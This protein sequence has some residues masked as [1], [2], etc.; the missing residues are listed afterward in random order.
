[1]KCITD[2]WSLCA[3]KW[4]NRLI[5]CTGHDGSSDRDCNEFC[6]SGGAIPQAL[7]SH[8]TLS[9]WSL[10]LQFNVCSNLA[11]AQLS[12]AGLHCMPH[13]P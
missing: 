10:S 3:K 5:A 4:R 12:H 8:D 7:I 1:M 13:A 11:P 9:F 6:W 2:C